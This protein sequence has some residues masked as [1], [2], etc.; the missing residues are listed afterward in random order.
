M[1][2][3]LDGATPARLRLGMA[4]LLGILF[5]CVAIASLAR[6][7]SVPLPVDITFHID[8]NRASQAELE[9]LHGIGPKL[10][11][12]IIR[13]REAMAADRRGENPIFL[14]PADL[15]NVAGID[16]RTVEEFASQLALPKQ[17]ALRDPSGEQP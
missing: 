1:Q 13:Y 11:T 2:A 16:R 12:E 7:W 17:P 9:L 5:A 6:T 8:P 14:V 10:A 4:M 3:A 15:M